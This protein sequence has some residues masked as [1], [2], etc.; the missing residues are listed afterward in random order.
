MSCCR[1]NR[2]AYWLQK[3]HS[4][5][6]TFFGGQKL[7][8]LCCIMIVVCKVGTSC[9]AVFHLGGQTTLFWSMF[10]LEAGRWQWTWRS[11]LGLKGW[12][13]ISMRRFWV[14]ACENWTWCKLCRSLIQIWSP[15]IR[16]WNCW[17][18]SFFYFLLIGVSDIISFLSKVKP[19][20]ATLE[21]I[22][23]YQWKN[24]PL[25]DFCP[26]SLLGYMCCVWISI[27]WFLLRPSIS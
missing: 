7:S 15:W 11:V 23:F 8:H 25:P 21:Q 14:I 10:T 2:T 13:L 5:F 18:I 17:G 16:F 12:S 3:N 26:L 19:T 4:R 24:W 27:T 20:R 1:T 9:R 6:S 22:W